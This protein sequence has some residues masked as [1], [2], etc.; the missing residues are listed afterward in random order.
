MSIKF[1]VMIV[2]LL[3]F[4]CSSVNVYFMYFEAVLLAKI[5]S[6]D[7]GPSLA[8]FQSASGSEAFL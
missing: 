2:D 4:L 5:Q 8:G 7:I 3:I 1:S 6:L